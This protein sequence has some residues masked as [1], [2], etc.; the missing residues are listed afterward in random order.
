MGSVL[1]FKKGDGMSAFFKV[2]S[3]I[4]GDIIV[5]FIE[6]HLALFAVHNKAK[7]LNVEILMVSYH[8][9]YACACES[10]FYI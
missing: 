8:G 6:S 10:H 3:D 7:L 2:T 9:G 1:P 5:I 4:K